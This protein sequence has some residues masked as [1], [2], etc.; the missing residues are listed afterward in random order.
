MS[1]TVVSPCVHTNN[2]PVHTSCTSSSLKNAQKPT[3]TPNVNV[4]GEN[5]CLCKQIKRVTSQL[6]THQE[7]DGAAGR[8]HRARLQVTHLTLTSGT[9][10]RMDEETQLKFMARVWSLNKHRGVRRIQCLPL[11]GAKTSHLQTPLCLSKP[12]SLLR[13]YSVRSGR[14]QIQ[15]NE[16]IGGKKSPLLLYSLYLCASA[17]L[18]LPD[19][20]RL[21]CT[22]KFTWCTSGCCRGDT[23]QWNP[24]RLR[25]PTRGLQTSSNSAT[26]VG[27][28]GCGLTISTPH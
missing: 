1:Y 26:T 14:P 27:V 8:Q 5:S 28:A 23:F 21:L 15:Q 16:R 19:M 9:Y 17:N 20:P 18:V 11:K 3:C 25:N 2:S 7:E 24:Q 12:L 6:D 13:N 10:L 22:D 4:S